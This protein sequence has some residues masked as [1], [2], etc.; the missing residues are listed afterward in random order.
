[1]NANLTLPVCEN[2]IQLA[3]Q[4]RNVERKVRDTREEAVKMLQSFPQ[5]NSQKI[6]AGWVLSSSLHCQ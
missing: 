2:A 3:L 4:E 5:M 6:G 1:L